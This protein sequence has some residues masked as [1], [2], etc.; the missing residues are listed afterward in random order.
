MQS[1]EFATVRDFNKRFP[2]KLYI[3][4]RCKSLITDPYIC[5]QCDN[6]NNNFLYTDNT[7]S[8]SI[9]ETGKTERIFKPL[10]LEKGKN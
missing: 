8:Y 4:P 3:C 7:Y 2:S 5:I 10:E 9:K 6:Q 1:E